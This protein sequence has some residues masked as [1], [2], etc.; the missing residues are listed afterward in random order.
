MIKASCAKVTYDGFVLVKIEHETFVVVIADVTDKT[1]EV[2]VSG[3][4]PHFNVETAMPGQVCVWMNA[5]D[6]VL[7]S[8]DRTMKNKPGLVDAVVRSQSGWERI[9][10]S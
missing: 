2:C 3:S 10:P 7:G 1:M 8:M 4:R 9:F 6:I 5:I